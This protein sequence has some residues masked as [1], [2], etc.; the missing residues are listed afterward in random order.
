VAD[1]IVVGADERV[2]RS[3][4]RSYG[5]VADMLVTFP[6]TGAEQFRS[7]LRDQCSTDWILFLDGDEVVGERL[8]TRI[9]SLLGDRNIAG[10][11]L[12]RDWLYPDPAHFIAS[13]PWSP[14]Y[15]V[16]LVRN[17]DRLW[18][19]A[20]QHTGPLTTGPTKRVEEP[21]LHLDL[22]LSSF[23]ERRRKIARYESEHFGHMTSGS[24]TNERFYLPELHGQLDYGLVSTPDR[25]H[26]ER[27]L[28]AQACAGRRRTVQVSRRATRDDIRR[29]LVWAPF[30]DNDALA[31]I[32]FT[33]P[34]PATVAAGSRFLIDIAVRNLGG[35]CWP[36]SSDRAPAVRV[37]YHW[38]RSGE[39]I[40]WDG[41]RTTL[42][43]P[44]RPGD[45]A[46]MECLVEAP[47]DTGNL[48]L[49]LD[50]LVE[51]DR[52]FGLTHAVPVRSTPSIESQLHGS[53]FDGIV[54]I[55]AML[56]IRA[57][58]ALPDELNRQLARRR[59]P[60]VL[61]V[62]I[63]DELSR[64]LGGADAYDPA[65]VAAVGARIAERRHGALLLEYGSGAST[66][67][68]AWI[69]RQQACERGALV[70]VAPDRGIADRVSAALQRFGL[71][72]LVHVAS[73]PLVD[74]TV[75]QLTLVSY[76]PGKVGTALAGRSPEVVAIGGPPSSRECQK[77]PVLPA[78]QPLLREPASFLVADA[79]RDVELAAADR[80]SRCTGI[81]VGGI[82]LEGAGVL[83]GAV[84]PA[85][86]ELAV[87]PS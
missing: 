39:S 48:E 83:V 32:R 50:V 71:A 36:A 84:Q 67:A 21:L 30:S 26:V 56:T 53:A 38:N 24:S 46:S 4:L 37:S 77:F 18:F 17:D 10:Y 66:V 22:L 45:V 43:H 34:P 49:T 31:E 69:L 25:R 27:T 87:T 9:G 33:R 75:D 23:D 2:D 28:S 12:R 58:L 44:V 60:D 47:A 19:P 72:D 79:F 74:V 61:P 13:A 55:E 7:W 1:E 63:G 64:L 41:I 81:S 73:A 6:Y 20:R 85:T 68:L 54:P 29:T 65:F 76:E 62:E 82:L 11:L 8:L 59:Q 14:D 80:W 16:R 15:Q 70:S 51:D 42:P 40:V 52:W 3:D 57:E 5:A 35:R 78:L 86:P